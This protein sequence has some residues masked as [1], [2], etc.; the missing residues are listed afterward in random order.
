MIAAA[1]N[2]RLSPELVLV[3]PEDDRLAAVA[4][5]PM[6]ERWKPAAYVVAGAR[7]GLQLA[8]I[9]RYTVER[10]V[11]TALWNGAIALAIAVLVLLA[12]MH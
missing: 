1:G 11:S 3:L 8:V 12:A 10:L 2:A 5:L 6:P 9:L 4:S 7:T